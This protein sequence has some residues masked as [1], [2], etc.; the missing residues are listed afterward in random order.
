MWGV[1]VKDNAQIPVPPYAC[2]NYTGFMM[3][4]IVDP[5]KTGIGEPTSFWLEHATGRS[6]IPWD[7]YATPREASYYFRYPTDTE[8]SEA[9]GFPGAA[10]KYIN[11]TGINFG[12]SG[13]NGTVVFQNVTLY[14]DEKLCK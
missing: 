6:T 5:N 10:H 1:E 8:L 2:Y 14:H 4:V 11:K 7:Q 12:V 3:Y 9:H 13:T